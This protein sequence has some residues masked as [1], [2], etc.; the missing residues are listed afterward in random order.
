MSW[1]LTDDTDLSIGAYVSEDH[2]VNIS[3]T[4]SVTPA[5]AN[6]SVRATG[7]GL[8]NAK[9]MVLLVSNWETLA[10]WICALMCAWMSFMMAI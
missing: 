3:Y 10:L 1:D 6:S 7:E 5:S 2:G 9:R 4:G 8:S